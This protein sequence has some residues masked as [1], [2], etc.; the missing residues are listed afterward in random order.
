MLRG[1][2]E[3]KGSASGGAPGSLQWAKNANLDRLSFSLKRSRPYV[4]SGFID[5]E[6]KLDFFQ[7]GPVGF[8]GAFREGPERC[9]GRPES[10]LGGPRET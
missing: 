10:L 5:F 3:K 1:G 9:I 7:F 2:L 8:P 4:Y 6:K